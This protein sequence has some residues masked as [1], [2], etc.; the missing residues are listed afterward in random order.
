[1]RCSFEARIGIAPLHGSRM[2]LLGQ[3]QMMKP[4]HLRRV[5]LRS[6]PVSPEGLRLKRETMP[7]KCGGPQRSHFR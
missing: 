1:M 7:D 3:F 5:E 4:S 2:R 6:V